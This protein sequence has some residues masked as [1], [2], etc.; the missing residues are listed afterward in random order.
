[1]QESNTANRFGKVFGIFLWLIVLLGILLRL[2]VYLQNRDLI[3]DEA[4][5]ARNLFEKSYSELALPLKYEQYAPPVFLWIEKLST[6]LFGFGE[7]SLKLYPL[8]T[9]IAALFFM[10][11]VLL[12]FMSPGAAWLPLL[13][14]ASTYW[15]ILYSTTVKQYMPDAMI[16]LILVWLALQYDLFTTSKSRFNAIW[17]IAGMLAIW[18][19]MPSVFVL[20]GVGGYYAWLCR[21]NRNTN[22]FRQLSI[23][24]IIWLINFTVYYF[25]ILK[26][27]VGLSNLQAYHANYFLIATPANA[28]EWH[29]NWARIR[30]II[31]NLGG[32][33][34][35][36]YL[37]TVLLCSTGLIALFIKRKDLF[38]LLLLPVAVTLVA[39]ALR[40]FSLIDRVILFMMPLLLLVLGYGFAQIMR[41]K[42]I[43]VKLAGMGIGVFIIAHYNEYK[44]FKEQ[45][46][47]PEIGK[48]LDYVN[49]SGAKGSELFIHHATTPVY[50]Y[51][52]QIAPRKP[53]WRKL[54][55]AH[56]LNWDTD[57]STVLKGHPGKSYFIYTGGLNPGDIE[58]YSVNIAKCAPVTNTFNAFSSM[59]MTYGD[60]TCY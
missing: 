11:A 46:P 27:Q 21:H 29:H 38:V 47:S 9:G 48:A 42:Y 52:T 19:S 60:N 13:M 16:A 58:K 15:Y 28:H 25:T 51:Y 14:M 56:L 53:G 33:R 17:I 39:A 8:L 37:L 55:G 2:I 23:I 22:K 18:S 34:Y 26:S 4:N 20:I 45:L 6:Q 43:P 24:V 54:E 5:I 10:R 49:A 41:L 50:I 3:I 57:Y 1:M 35:M 30:E 59:V 40:K 32:Y 36:G 12:K 44:F 31:S 7:L